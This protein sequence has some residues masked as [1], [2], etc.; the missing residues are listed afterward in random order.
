M[1]IIDNFL[2]TSYFNAIKNYLESD[3]FDW[4]YLDGISTID[5]KSKKDLGF[6]HWI[7]D[8]N[9]NERPGADFF[10]GFILQLQ[11]IYPDCGKVLRCRA[12][13]VFSN[14]EPYIHSPHIDIPDVHHYSIIF[15]INESDG[16]TI[17]YNEK[18]KSNYNINEN[19]LTIKKIIN[20]LPNRLIIFDG[21]YIHTGSSPTK[22]TRRIIINTNLSKDI[23]NLRET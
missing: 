15:Y 8:L 9:G 20:P 4:Y 13:M 23:N 16:D 11:D 18:S 17:I 14:D 7:I 22:F 2:T 5:R 3:S 10:A 6:Y 1:K 12:D 19:D 21:D